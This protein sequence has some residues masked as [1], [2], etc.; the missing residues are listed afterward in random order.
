M[1][2]GVRSDIVCDAA[3]PSA[4]R[5]CCQWGGSNPWCSRI[6]D[7]RL[8]ATRRDQEDCRRKV[9]RLQDRERMR[10][11]GFKT[12]VEGDRHRVFWN[13]AIL[14]EGL[15]DCLKRNYVTGRFLKL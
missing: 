6:P 1:G 15:D 7:G 14:S 8:T 9:V 4:L 12:V 13:L 11:D 10:V 3:H 5:L 2:G